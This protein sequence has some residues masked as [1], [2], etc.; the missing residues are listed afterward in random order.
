MWRGKSFIW[1]I[2][3]GWW[4]IPVYYLCIWWWLTPITKLFSPK[5]IP[6]NQIPNFA[7]RSWGEY[8]QNIATW[9]H[10]NARHQWVNASFSSKPLYE[11][12]WSNAVVN[13]VAEPSNEFDTQA[14]AVYLDGMHIGYVPHEI[15]D[16][17]HKALLAHPRVYAKIH[18]GS[19]KF[20]D[21]YGDLIVT[22]RDPIVELVFSEN[23]NSDI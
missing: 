5:S 9:Q 11:Y 16:N 13:L 17:F 19:A 12:S 10:N 14:I 4:W 20:I 21:E 6:T 23:Y 1:W 7:V 22:K 3:I 15:N 8:L 2:L 18:G